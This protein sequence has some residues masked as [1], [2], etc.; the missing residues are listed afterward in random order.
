MYHWAKTRLRQLRATWRRWRLDDGSLVAA[1]MAYYT[2]LSFFPLLLLLIAVLGFV[3]RFSSGAQDAQQELLR[4][5]AQN[6]SPSLAEH[7]HTALTAI[8]AKAVVGGPLGVLV[9]LV[10]AIGV[11]TQLDIGMKRIWNV[12]R[13]PRGIA[14]TVL[15]VLF[16]RLRAFLLLLA[17]GALVWVAF[18]AGTIAAAVRPM[19]EG[20]I[21]GSIAWD[22]VHIALSLVVNALLLTL[23]YKL[24]PPLKVAWR[25][26][27]RGGLLAAML[28]EISRQALSLIM[29]G[30]QY[31]AYGVVG[32]LMALM[33]WI[34]IAASIFFFAAEY[35]RVIEQDE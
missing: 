17:V 10:A 24:L 3:L 11:F 4:I 33:L 16:H 18:I 1:S 25:S 26:A 7:V 32:S 30:K 34:Y 29:F 27:A 12:P 8:R 13:T 2:A 23:L 9:L 22:S 28:W 15:H 6:T 35:V 20:L 19:A 21:G 5:V 14:A 31:T